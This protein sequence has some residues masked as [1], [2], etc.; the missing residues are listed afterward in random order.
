MWTNRPPEHPSDLPE[1]RRVVRHVGVHHDGDDDRYGV[2]AKR[3]VFGVG[4][5][6]AQAMA[7]VPQHPGRDIDAKGVPAKSAD[8][9]GVDAGSAAEFQA[10]ALARP[11]SSR[12]ASATPIG[13][14]SEWAVGRNCS[15][16]QSAIAS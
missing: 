15:S 12:S 3:Q 9:A 2:V 6:H 4:Q 8:R 11:S 16:Y 10:D 1:N 5:R 7:S 14:S 13:S